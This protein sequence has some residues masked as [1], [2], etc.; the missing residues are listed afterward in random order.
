MSITLNDAETLTITTPT[1]AQVID[2]DRTGLYAVS[3]K[4]AAGG[5]VPGTLY[6][7]NLAT[8]IITLADPLSLTGHA[9]PWTLTHSKRLTLPAALLW[10][11]RYEWRGGLSTAVKPSFGGAAVIEEFQM[12]AGREIRLEPPSADLAVMTFEDTE[13][14]D[15]WQS[16]PLKR[17]EL[18]IRGE[19]FNVQFGDDALTAKP[20]LGWAKHEAGERWS[21]S[22]FFITVE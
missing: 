5:T 9:A 10:A 18:N 20:A 2:C 13:L 14:L 7:A 11:N 6:S 19:V 8:G 12:L 17:M 15:A 3:I 21:N 4:N 1:A 22:L 16:T